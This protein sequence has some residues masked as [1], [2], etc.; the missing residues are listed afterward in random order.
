M[1]VENQ[2]EDKK[3]PITLEQYINN[4]AG[5]GSST[6]PSIVRESIMNSYKRRFDNLLLRE[7]GK[8]K[9]YQ[10]KNTENNIYYTL[11]KVPSETIPDFYYDVVFKFY[12]DAGVSDGGRD[13]KKYYVQFFSNDPSF[14]Y[15]YAYVFIQKN[16]FLTELKSKLS[17]Q[18]VREKPTERNP[19]EV[20]NYVKSI[21]FA[22][23]FLNERGLLNKATF[24]S[25]QEFN[26]NELLRLVEDAEDKIADRQKEDKKVNHRK[27]IVV[28]DKNLA[29]KLKRF[30]IGDNPMSR[31]VF[32]TKKSVGVKKTDAVNS[33]KNVKKTKRR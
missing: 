25:A 18:V 27:K 28:N 23:L 14:V 3:A 8:I 21:V 1:A 22:Y 17:M 24:G 26:I 2:Y 9:Y 13:L 33:V 11:V 7:N 31:V 32:T 15:T 4:P 12:T 30:G 19:D 16:L 5:K 6:V 20:V 29:N 10:Y